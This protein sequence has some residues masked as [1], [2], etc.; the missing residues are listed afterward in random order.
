MMKII[1]S[2]VDKAAINGMPLASFPGRVIVVQSVSEAEKAVGYL[3]GQ[4]IVGIDTETRPAFHKGQSFGVALVQ[5]STADTCF[6]FRLNMIGFPPVLKEFFEAESPLKVGLSLRDD[7]SRLHRMR[8]F[9]Q[10]G[11]VELQEYVKRMG[12]E[13]QSLQ[14]IFAILFGQKISKAQRLTNWEADVL[15]DAQKVYAATDAWACLKIYNELEALSASGDYIIEK[16][17]E[18]D[19]STEER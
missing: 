9:T 4:P 5:I 8:S 15:T 19:S 17:D 13:A 7:F 18:Q 11:N 3:S 12:M 16:E 6:L 1:K 10:R 2:N 14:K